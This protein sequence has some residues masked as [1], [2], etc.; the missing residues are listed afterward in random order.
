[1]GGDTA[2]SRPVPLTPKETT[3]IRQV[4]LLHDMDPGRTPGTAARARETLARLDADFNGETSIFGKPGQSVLKTRWK[5]TERDLAKAKKMIEAT[6]YP[7]DEPHFHPFYKEHGTPANYF[8]KTVGD[9]PDPEAVAFVK[10]EGPLLATL[11]KS[12]FYASVDFPT[13]LNAVKGLAS[14]ITVGM[15]QKPRPEGTPPPKP[16]TVDMLDTAGFMATIKDTEALPP[17][18]QQN[19]KAVQEGFKAF[20]EARTKGL[21]EDVAADAGNKAYQDTLRALKG[22]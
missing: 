13:A 14:E 7:F 12:S 1:M 11:D 21:V 3:F 4:G 15:N 18:Y 5:W 10:R 2:Q 20:K 9:L 16:M 6:E 19:F 8:A 22:E 17:S